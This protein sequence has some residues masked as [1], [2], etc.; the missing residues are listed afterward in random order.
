MVSNLSKEIEQFFFQIISWFIPTR[1]Q[2]RSNFRLFILIILGALLL[3]PL[4]GRLPMAGWDWYLFFNRNNPTFNISSPTSAYPP[5]AHLLIDPLTK[6]NWRNSLAILNAVT[7]I[8]VALATWK[9]GGRYL[10]I[11]LVLLTPPLWYL[12]WI[13]HPDGLCL[14]GLITGFI[15]LALIKPQLTIFSMLSRKTLLAWTGFF[16]IVTLLI[17]PVWILRV[18][19]ATLTHEAAFGW[20]VTGWP[21]LIVGLV[22]LAGAGSNP[23]RLMA[24][25]LLISPYLMPYNLAVLLPIIGRVRGSKKIIVWASVWLTALGVGL[26]GPARY[27]NLVFPVVSYWMTHSIR[28][29]LNNV[30]ALIK[31]PEHYFEILFLKT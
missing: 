2:L 7:L 6:L 21:I 4:V 8:T 24:A 22:L 29:Y 17:W 18:Q 10:S 25:G 13:G 5:Y 20:V 30:A 11:L 26:G 31:L 1:Y 27:L 15:P 19:S 16:L 9:N 3:T 12:M 23:Y 28:D 14:L